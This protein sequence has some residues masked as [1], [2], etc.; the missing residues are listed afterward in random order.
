M[1]GTLPAMF[2]MAAAT[3]IICKLAGREFVP[4]TPLKLTTAQYERQLTRLEDREFERFGTT[5][6]VAVDLDEASLPLSLAWKQAE[7][8]EGEGWRNRNG[9]ETV[10]GGGCQRRWD[11]AETEPHRIVPSR[12]STLLGS[13]GEASVPGHPA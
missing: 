11:V 3:Y 7:V 10:R 6:G 12:L 9:R 5:D 8:Q 4:D 13:C 2:G 1:L